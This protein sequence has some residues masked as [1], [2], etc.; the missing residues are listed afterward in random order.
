PSSSPARRAAPASGGRGGRPLDGNS[1]RTSRNRTPVAGQ[2]PPRRPLGDL[3][4]H[5]AALPRRVVDV[6]DEVGERGEVKGIVARRQ[7][8]TPP[9]GGGG[10]ELEQRPQLLVAERQLEQPGAV[11]ALDSNP[12]NARVGTDLPRN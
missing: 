3:V 2:P 8:D 9:A 7:L 1:D 10:G 11:L 12:T 4:Q 6:Q 5:R